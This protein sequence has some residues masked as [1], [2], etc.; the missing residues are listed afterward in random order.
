MDPQKIKQYK[1]FYKDFAEECYKKDRN[2]KY[3]IEDVYN[4]VKDIID[5]SNDSEDS[6]EKIIGLI[7]AIKHEW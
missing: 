1:K 5:N 6:T 3:I 7:T 4:E 2:K